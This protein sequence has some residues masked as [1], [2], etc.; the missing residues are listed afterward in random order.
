MMKKKFIIYLIFAIICSNILLTVIIENHMANKIDRIVDEQKKDIMLQSKEKIIT[1][2]KI[3]LAMDQELREKNETSILQISKEIEQTF[4]TQSNIT[5]DELKNLRKKFDVSEIYIIDEKGKIIYTSFLQDQDLN[6]FQTGKAFEKFLKSLYGQG[7]IKHQ[8]ITVSSNSGILNKYV[9]YSPKESSYIIEVSMN[10][11]E[12]IKNNYPKEYYEFVFSRLFQSVYDDN[13]YL[14]GMDVY[15]YN[16]LSSWSLLHVGKKF[17]K[18]KEFIDKLRK[19]KKICMKTENLNRCYNAFSLDSSHYDFTRNFY[20]EFIYDFSSLEKNKREIFIFAGVVSFI[21]IL[22]TF[23]ISSEI[24]NIHVIQKIDTINHGLKMIEKGEYDYDMQLESNDELGDI[25]NNINKMKEIIKIR[26]GELIKK[27][28]QIH[29]LAYYD[30]LTGLPNRILFE[31]KLAKALE[32]GKQKNNKVALLYFDLD[33]FK[34]VND[35]IGHMFGDLL[36]KNVGRLLKKYLGEDAIATRMG[37]DEFVGILSKV[38][39]S[40]ELIEI[41]ENVLNAFRNPWII[42][43]REFYVTTSIGITLYPDDGENTNV[44]LK[45]ADTAMYVAKNHGKNMYCFYTSDMNEK[46]IEKLE[47]ENDLRH[48]VEREEFIV[49]YQPKVDI[50]S[51]SI[52]GVEALVRWMHPSKG[53]IPPDK[54]IALAEETGL[55]VPI[56]EWVLR[57][58]CNQNKVWQSLGYNCMNV[59]VNISVIQIQQ[60]DFVEKIMSILKETG[61]KPSSLELEITEN[62]IMEDFKLTSKMLHDLRKLGIKISLDD[63]GKGY[64]SLNYLKQLEIDILKIDKSFIDDLVESDNE[65]A[66]VKAVIDMAHSMKMTVVAEGVEVWDQFTFLKNLYCDKVQG[67]LFSKPLPVNEIESIIEGNMKVC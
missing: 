16:K 36:L 29:Y 23:F 67:Y 26:E 32:E 6:V 24:L 59:A 38:N 3:L 10:I 42:D 49:Y 64:S 5:Q 27:Q 62:V 66:I 50:N 58:A 28:D 12:Y 46:V 63:F 9:Y 39:D 31:E 18:S 56:G 65:Q 45:N 13:E 57:T 19:E 4:K 21:I 51:G 52:A 33:N 7:E 43:D 41:I 2:D 17:E 11:H 25:V 35:T 55:I 40:H 8:N 47:M 1:F 44:L 54:F 30:T 15:S 34:N 60:P 22:I 14:V 53:M 61:I 20:V 48:A 37:G